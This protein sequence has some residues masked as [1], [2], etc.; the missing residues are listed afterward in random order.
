MKRMRNAKQ[1]DRTS[2]LAMRAISREH[3]ERVRG[4]T[5]TLASEQT[6]DEAGKATPELIL[7]CAVGRHV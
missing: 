4:G 3:L 6:E 2:P 5:E 1:L 7:K